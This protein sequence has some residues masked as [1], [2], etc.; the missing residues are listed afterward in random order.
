MLFA[1]QYNLPVEDFWLP[2]MTQDLVVMITNKANHLRL[3]IN[4]HLAGQGLFNLSTILS[5]QI[6]L[7][8]DILSKLLILLSVNASVESKL[9]VNK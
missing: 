2:T 9:I 8:E 4:T 5:I 1:A 3:L 6:D 7:L